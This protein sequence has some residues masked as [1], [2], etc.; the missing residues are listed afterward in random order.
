MVFKMKHLNM[1]LSFLYPSPPSKKNEEYSL[2]IG[3]S[4]IV[5]SIYFF[6]CSFPHFSQHFIFF[7]FGIPSNARVDHKITSLFHVT[8]ILEV[9]L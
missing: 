2:K 4:Y 5:K 7:F 9:L 1:N 8:C 3:A 6:K